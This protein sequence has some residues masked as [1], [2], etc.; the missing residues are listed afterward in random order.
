MDSGGPGKWRGG[1]GVEKVYRITSPCRVNL[2]FD[3]TKCPPW[4]VRGGGP[5]KPGE[6][7]IRRVS[8]EIQRVLKGDHPLYTGDLVFVRTGGG[9][10]YGLPH[11]RDIRSVVS[12]VRQGYVSL[13]AARG[14]Y[15]VAVNE[16]GTADPVKTAELRSIMRNCKETSR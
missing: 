5:G 13:E 2:K 9:G 16:D 7:E 8:G 10:G 15:G 6:V 4:G 1:L 3:R 14:E 11:E 12:D